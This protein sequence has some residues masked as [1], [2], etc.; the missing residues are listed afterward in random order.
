MANKVGKYKLLTRFIA[1][2]GV[3]NTILEN[4]HTG[5]FPSTKQ[6]D[7]SDVKVVTP[8]GEIPWKDLSRFN[9]REM[10]ELMLDIEKSIY[11]LFLV[12]HFKENVRVN[13]SDKL[14]D[15]MR[16]SLFGKEGVSW[17]ITKRE[18]NRLLKLA[19]KEI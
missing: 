15:N 1:N 12:L 11:N 17:D 7:Y 8:Y 13:V 10:R 6:G 14:L 16:E 4:L 19:R 9:D 18:Y 3:R 2:Y 5:I